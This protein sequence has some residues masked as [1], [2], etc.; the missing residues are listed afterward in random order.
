MFTID[1]MKEDKK[2]R[3]LRSWSE[4]GVTLSVI[5][6]TRRAKKNT[7]LFPVKFC[8]TFKRKR[9][10]YPS[11]Y[12][13]KNEWDK[14]TAGK[15]I[16]M[17][18]LKAANNHI[19]EEF[20]RI[21][22]IISDISEREGF[23]FVAV[24]TRLSQGTKTSLLDAFNQRVKLL[25]ENGKIGTAD[26]Y[27]Y[28]SKSISTFSSSEDPKLSDISPGWLDRYEKHLLKNNKSS[29]TIAMYMRALRAILNEALRKQVIIQSQYPFGK[30]KY[31][32]KEG[33]GGKTALSLLQIS[34]LLK[35]P[36]LSVSGNRYRD[37]WFFSYLCNGINMNDLF[38][39]KYKNLINGEIRFLRRKTLN[40]NHKKK[41]IIATILPEMNQ[42]INKWGNTD[43]K[44]GNYIFPLLNDTMTPTE[45]KRV[46]SNITRSINQQM[47]K[48]GKALGYGAISTY[49]ARH[50]FA[51]ILKRS[52]SSIEYISE[53]L[54]HRNLN[55]TE[56]YLA[57][58][59][60]E[61]RAKNAQNLI[62]KND[63]A[64]K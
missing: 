6:D 60:S 42:I 9:V 40:T 7:D 33:S 1:N 56:N 53:S 19:N 50:S 46:I 36:I 31:E 52:G 23:T 51:T 32:I 35:Y 59:E 63:E 18:T 34:E 14:L 45:E 2:S 28:T 37:L 58:F 39:L 49:T 5:H 13:T 62:L 20:D 15:T 17:K 38:R 64:V 3:R 25:T 29:T 11:M 26:W 30:N 55:T 41:E 10:Y 12:L 44:K 47:H 57:Y 24:N 27:K 16:K 61:Q 48:I 43:Q 22:R 4:S 54:G 8:I 21:K